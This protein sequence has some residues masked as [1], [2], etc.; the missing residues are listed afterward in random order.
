MVAHFRWYSGVDTDA[1]LVELTGFHRYR[2]SYHVGVFVI[3]R[4]K[5]LRA[6][7]IAGG[8]DHD[9]KAG[10]ET[11]VHIGVKS[12]PLQKKISTARHETAVCYVLRVGEREFGH[13]MDIRAAA[14]PAAPEGRI[15]RQRRLC[16]LS[17]TRV[18][19]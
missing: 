11:V 1:V 5:V 9:A 16:S 17:L 19:L 6:R 15:R 8:L 4:L 7:N 18:A 13:S 10:L 3:P 14:G 12:R 2:P